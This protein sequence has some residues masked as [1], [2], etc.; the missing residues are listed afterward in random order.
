[1]FRGA[2]VGAEVDYVAY[3]AGAVGVADEEVVGFEVVLY[4]NWR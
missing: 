2:P 4:G 3:F 1:M